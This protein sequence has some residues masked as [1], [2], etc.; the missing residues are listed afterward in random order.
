M[1]PV[2]SVRGGGP[3]DQLP[4]WGQSYI[5]R[6]PGRCDPLWSQLVRHGV[7]DRR[8]AVRLVN[9]QL[10]GWGSAGVSSV[11]EGSL[12]PPRSTPTVGRC[13]RVRRWAKRLPR[14]EC[15]STSESR[16]DLSFGTV[17]QQLLM[18]IGVA[19]HVLTTPFRELRKPSARDADDTCTFPQ[20]RGLTSRTCTPRSSRAAACACPCMR[21]GS[22][23]RSS[24]SSR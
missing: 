24:G 23:G 15:G 14:V 19:C 17:H 9:P 6:P 13:W 12:R 4:V 21:H 22:E 18:H 16:L 1:L 3:R 10:G 5:L 7:D 20:L 11:A 2:L 8:R